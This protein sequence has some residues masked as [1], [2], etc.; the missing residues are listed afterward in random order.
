MAFLAHS[1][2]QP[3]VRH[4]TCA[5]STN[6]K[7]TT[8][9]AAATITTTT[10]TTTTTPAKRDGSKQVTRVVVVDAVLMG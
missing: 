7:T 2:K 3:N 5:F 4:K 10:T 1:R 8:A 6:E 9:A